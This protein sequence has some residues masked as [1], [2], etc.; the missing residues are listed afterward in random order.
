MLTDCDLALSIFFFFYLE[1]FF[2]VPGGLA[3]AKMLIVIFLQQ[4]SKVT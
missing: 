4:P 3:N 1:G 2:N